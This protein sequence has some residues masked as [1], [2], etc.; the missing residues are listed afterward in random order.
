MLEFLHLLPQRLHLVDQVERLGSPARVRQDQV[1][2]PRPRRLVVAVEQLDQG[3]Y[4]LR[5][6]LQQLAHGAAQ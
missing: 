3:V 1:R 2:C 6:G 4:R 5:R